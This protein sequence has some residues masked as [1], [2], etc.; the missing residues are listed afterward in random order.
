MK[1]IAICLLFVILTAQV[2]GGV[3]Y[4]TDDFESWSIDSIS[5]WDSREVSDPAT[6][7]ASTTTEISAA[8]TYSLKCVDNS[9]T[10]ANAYLREDINAGTTVYFRFYAYFK[11]DFFQQIPD[12]NFKTIFL[13]YDLSYSS[14]IYLVAQRDPDD[15][16]KNKTRILTN[17]GFGDQWSTTVIST[18]T[19]YCFEIKTPS[20]T[21]N[22]STMWW[23][24]GVEQ[25]PSTGDYRAFDEGFGYPIFLGLIW[26]GAVMEHTAY[27]DEVKWSDE[28]IGPLPMAS[29]EFV[30][31][32]KQSGGDFDTVSGWESAI[33]CDLTHSTGTRVFSH[34]G[35]VGS[36]IANGVTL[37]GEDSNA[38]G[39]ATRVTATQVLLK[40]TSGV[41]TKGEQVYLTQ[42]V[43]YIEISDM[44]APAIAVA[45]I[46]GTWSVV[47]GAVDINGWSTSRENYIKIYT[48]GSARH[49][50]VWSNTAHRL[51]AARGSGGLIHF[52]EGNVWIDGLQMEN[53]SD[54]SDPWGTRQ[55]YNSTNY[56]GPGLQRISNCIIRYPGPPSVPDAWYDCA[57][58]VTGLYQ[59]E[60]QIWNNIMYGFGNGIWGTSLNNNS[61]FYIYNNTIVDCDVGDGG[62]GWGIRLDG[63]SSMGCLYM[64]NN[65]VQGDYTCFYTMDTDWDVIVTSSNIANDATSPDNYFDNRTVSFQNKDTS[66]YFLVS[67]DTAAKDAGIDLSEDAYLAFNDDIEGDI[68]P[69][70]S[71]WDIGADETE[72]IFSDDFEEW[73]ISDTGPWDS[74]YTSEAGLTLSTETFK[75]AGTYGLKCVDGSAN[76][77]VYLIENLPEASTYYV[78]FYIYLPDDFYDE[79][80]P[81]DFVH[82][83]ELYGSG[84]PRVRLRFHNSVNQPISYQET[85]G[86]TGIYPWQPNFST[87]TWH[88]IE[89]LA[90]DDVDGGTMEIWL[91]G[92]SLGT[93]SADFSTFG[94]WDELRFGIID[95]S[96][97]NDT[98]TIYF[99]ELVVDDEYIGTIDDTTAPDAV[100]NLSALT[101]TNEGEIDLTWTAPGDDG[102]DE[103]LTPGTYRIQYSTWTNWDAIVWSTNIATGDAYGDYVT[104]STAGVTP[105]DRESRTVTG[106]TS[107]VTYYFRIWTADEIPN[108]SDECI[109]GATAWAY[110][111]LYISVMSASLINSTTVRV[112]YSDAIDLSAE[113]ITNYS[114][115]P[116]VSIS[117]AAIRGIDGN[118][119]VELRFSAGVA[120]GKEY[121]VTVT[122][123]NN[124]LPTAS[125]ATFIGINPTPVFMDDF[126]RTRNSR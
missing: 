91:D 49:Q 81:N 29:T 32:I 103:R 96:D 94:N 13:A 9:A 82:V 108:W 115:D 44:G 101:G 67:T 35:T 93:N 119:V 75:K 42:D 87:G 111:S 50:G 78:R 92:Q 11:D 7:S 56:E 69:I 76:D 21:I 95:E 14:Y 123:V 99:D 117:S 113:F 66:Y 84:G 73:T 24:N 43:N 85:V 89:L 104:I 27:F 55:Y 97:V 83:Y 30:C 15:G 1:R 53:T 40:N 110:K 33:D 62:N 17:A 90:P 16:W 112:Y 65:L 116:A 114:L 109:P 10:G 58:D 22:Q 37:K 57:I 122:G 51:S 31:I 107:G 41:F 2:A 60:V 72:E 12:W 86:W 8:G 36:P 70:G 6:M 3:D 77:S 80:A 74:I 19:W 63:G 71:A 105:G 124:L 68:R 25:P 46:E 120:S 88:C 47:N 23:I 61:T 59:S 102:L 98:P 38:T 125:T 39:V 48:T 5:P 18:N 118:E 52:Y 64:K 28:Y 106:L 34:G 4:L 20:G 79:V 45:R 126:N 100:T 26:G 54:P 121:T